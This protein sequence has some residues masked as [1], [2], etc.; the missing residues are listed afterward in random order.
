MLLS[1]HIAAGGLAIVLGARV[2]TRSTSPVWNHSRVCAG[3]T[4]TLK[5]RE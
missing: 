4:P 5:Q 2:V 1:I 3:C